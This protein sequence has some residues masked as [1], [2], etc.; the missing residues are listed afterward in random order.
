MTEVGFAVFLMTSSD[1]P[2][3]PFCGWW[4]CWKLGCN[5]SL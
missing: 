1:D 3:N 2:M 5:T 4:F